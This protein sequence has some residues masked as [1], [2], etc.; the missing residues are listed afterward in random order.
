MKNYEKFITIGLTA[1]FLISLTALAQEQRLAV[2]LA[3]PQDYVPGQLLIKFLPGAP[4]ELISKAAQHLLARHIKTFE[5]IGVQHWRLGRGVSVEK[6]LEII[7]RPPFRDYIAYAEPNYIVHVDQQF[8]QFANDPR[9][10]DLWA[11][12]NI[13]QTGGLKDADIDALEAWQFQ[14]LNQPAPGAVVVGVI[15]TGIDYTH[16]DL[17]D[18]IWTNPGETPNN[19][20]DDDSNG[21]VDDMHGWDFFNNDSDPMDDNGHGTHVA[22]TIGAVGDNDIGV[23]GVSWQVKL[24]AVK[25]LGSCGSG[26]TSGAISAILYAAKFHV[27]ITN[28]SW[29]GG[30]R[31]KA[32]QDAIASSGALFVAAAGNSASSTKHYPAGYDLNNII[33]VAATEHNDLLAGFSNYSSTWVDLGAPGVDILSSIPNNGY[34]VKSGTSMASPHVAG[35]AALV[36]AYS[37][38]MSILEVKAIILGSVDPNAS[39][40]GITVTGGRLNALRAIGIE[41]P[42]PDDI[43]APAAVK[44]LTLSVLSPPTYDSITLSWTATGDDDGLIGGPAYLYD[45]R[46][47]AESIDENNWASATLA[48]GEPLPN[49]P[50]LLESFTLNGLVA[51]TYY[52]I[53]LKV[54]DESGNYSALSNEL[55]A[56]TL[57]GPKWVVETIDSGVFY[58]ALAYDPYGNPSI[59]YGGANDLVKFAKKVG[60]TWEIQTVDSGGPG[61]DLAYGPDRYPSISH[62]WGKLRFAH[63]NGSAWGVQTV[64]TRS[65]NDVTSLAYDLSGYPAIAYW[66]SRG[67]LKFARWNG[68]TWVIKTVDPAAG[69]RYK[70]LAYDKLGNPSIAYSDDIDGDGWLDTLKFYYYD[71]DESSWKIET[72][73]TGVVGYGVFASLAYDLD[74]N[75]SIVHR[76]AGIVYFHHRS[77][78]TWS[79][80]VVDTGSY[81]F[82]AYDKSGAPW[83]SYVDA[84]YT[85]VCVAKQLAPSSW[86]SEI[87]DRNLDPSWIVRL[88]FDLDGNPSVS[89]QDYTSKTL[90]FARRQDQ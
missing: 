24:M 70:S 36:M 20:I 5:R 78:S 3:E 10:G 49:N 83:V 29:G 61:I 48:Q 28:N 27:P 82:L 12:H 7:S 69:A 80:E 17:K 73:I 1:I 89:Y 22:G 86:Q 31:S 64:A 54:A 60:S 37:P 40:K 38:G 45:M 62:G 42:L 39:L 41:P 67:G 23:A 4:A 90:R 6:A 35:V 77:G 72:I 81:C 55:V 33:S 56:S 46:Y 88:A 47:S 63:W 58:N 11:M 66:V 87:I 30:N 32:L 21:Y 52:Y 9:R 16:P 34:G 74:G 19:G 53:A 2:E 85:E 68:S 44:D 59:G 75:P 51:G 18:N 25:F 57:Q 26:T 79:I 8:S 50:G 15:D 13:G 43:K 84:T 65:Y 71:Y 76:A 14:L